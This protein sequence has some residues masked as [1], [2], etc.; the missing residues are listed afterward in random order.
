[1]KKLLAMII[2]ILLLFGAA[3]AEEEFSSGEEIIYDSPVGY[4]TVYSCSTVDVDTGEQFVDE[5]YPEVFLI[6]N[7]DGTGYELLSS[8]GEEELQLLEWQ[9]T[10]TGYTVKASHWWGDIE[11][12]MKVDGSWLDLVSDYYETSEMHWENTLTFQREAVD[13][14][15]KD[16]H[17]EYILQEGE[18]FDYPW[19]YEQGLATDLSL[20]EDGVGYISRILDEPYTREEVTWEIVNRGIRYRFINCYTG[21]ECYLSFAQ[22]Y[23]YLIFDCDNENVKYVFAEGLSPVFDYA[24]PV[25]EEGSA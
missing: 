6:F 8:L 10:E 17:L 15:A 16:W 4:W 19:V 24:D 12:T 7:E 23:T 3:A 21:E 25:A 18:K 14:V 5:E 22:G 9:P 11:Y 1:M 20:G 13:P 2:S